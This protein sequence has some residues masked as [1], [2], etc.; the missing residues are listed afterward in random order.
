MISAVDCWSHILVIICL[1]FALC[2]Y[3]DI[4]WPKE[5]CF[6]YVHDT[7]VRRIEA[8]GAVLSIQDWVHIA[9]QNE[10][11]ANIFNELYGIHCPLKK[12]CIR[13]KE[14][15]WPW[16][17]KGL[18]NR[19]IICKKNTLNVNKNKYK[20]YKN[21]L[22]NILRYAGK[23]YYSNLLEKHSKDTKVTWKVL[24]SVIKINRNFTPFPDHFV[25]EYKT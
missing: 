16:F 20:K 7:Q 17:A 1:L 5:K 23:E 8:F 19:R 11:F 10:G 6:N 4:S 3:I 14:E 22:T 2:N 21:K 15:N 9:K 13:N 18:V 12:L 25:N 24:N